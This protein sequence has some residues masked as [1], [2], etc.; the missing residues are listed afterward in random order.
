MKRSP[1]YYPE[2]ELVQKHQNGEF[3][4]VDYIRHHSEAWCDEYESFCKEHGYDEEDDNAAREFV[5]HKNE[6]FENALAEGNA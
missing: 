6:E 2:D 3:N 5:D 4:W 1:I